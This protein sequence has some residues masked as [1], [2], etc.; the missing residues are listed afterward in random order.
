MNRVWSD[1][2]SHGV[3]DLSLPVVEGVEAGGDR[4]TTSCQAG[5]SGD[6]QSLRLERR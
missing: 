3:I 2:L 6:C 5:E 4:L 1:Q